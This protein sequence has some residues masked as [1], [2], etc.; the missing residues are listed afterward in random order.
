MFYGNKHSTKRV[1]LNSFKRKVLCYLF[2]VY[3]TGKQ[4][5]FLV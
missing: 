4:G 3:H 2:A 1:Y 5:K